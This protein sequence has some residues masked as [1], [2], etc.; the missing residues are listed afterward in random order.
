MEV[1]LTRSSSTAGVHTIAEILS[2]P[3]IWTQCLTQLQERGELVSLNQK[4]NKNVEWI[5]VGCG[6]SFY[7]AQIAAASWS[8]LTGT[9]ARA[10]PETFPGSLPTRFYFTFWAHIGGR[11]SGAV[12]R[13]RAEN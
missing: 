9:P 2:E 12:R 4:L 3:Q 6:S 11:R 10:I 1:C 5:F 7:L 8:I 13:A